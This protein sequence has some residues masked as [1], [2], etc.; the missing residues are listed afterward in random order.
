M[1]YLSDDGKVFNTQEECND[2]ESQIKRREVEAK[3]RQKLLE[4]NKKSRYEEI[5]NKNEELERLIDSYERDYG[6]RISFGNL[7]DPLIG[8]VRYMQNR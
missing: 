1:K 8:L 5:Q 7:S 6:L 3:A 2:Y 4:E